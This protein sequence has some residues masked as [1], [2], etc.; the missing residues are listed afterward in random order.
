M[1][2]VDLNQDVPNPK[3]ERVD[4]TVVGQ[5]ATAKSKNA[6]PQQ[7]MQVMKAHGL[8][9]LNTYQD[10]T[11]TYYGNW[12][13]QSRIEFIIGPYHMLPSFKK[14]HVSARIGRTLQCI[15]FRAKRDDYPIY[16]EFSTQS[17]VHMPDEKH[18]WDRDRAMTAVKGN[19]PIRK[20]FIEAIEETIE[21][22]EY[23]KRVDMAELEPTPDECWK[24]FHDEVI[25]KVA[26]EQFTFTQDKAD[27]DFKPFINVVKQDGGTLVTETRSLRITKKVT[28]ET[29]CKT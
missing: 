3:E 15:S 23:Q 19:F 18:R 12:N 5:H 8:C 17:T 11:A 27:K 10:S 13:N 2:A 28:T 26:K 9:F 6:V 16:A 22:E 4:P 24:I 25:H 29:N 20:Q 1:F 7:L 14:M 21:C